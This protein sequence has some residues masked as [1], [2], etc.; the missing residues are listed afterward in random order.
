MVSIHL[1]S[2]N[3]AEE[4]KRKVFAGELGLFDDAD[5]DDEEEGEGDGDENEGDDSFGASDF[6][7]TQYGDESKDVIMTDQHGDGP[8]NSLPPIPPREMPERDE[9][10][11]PI[12][13][14]NGI[15]P[16]IAVLQISALDVE[17]YTYNMTQSGLLGVCC[18]FHYEGYHYFNE[19]NKES[20]FKKHPSSELDN[21]AP[22]TLAD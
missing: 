11:L 6:S 17:S 10:G 16:A 3:A 22:T 2:E 4:L 5:A 14:T 8:H 12:I 7:V 20:S 18:A 13:K 21:T 9:L 15:N 1:V 19:S